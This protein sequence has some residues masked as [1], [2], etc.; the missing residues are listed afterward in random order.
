MCI[1]CSSDCYAGYQLRN[2][3]SVFRSIKVL[4][5]IKIMYL[6]WRHKYFVTLRYHL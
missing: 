6:Y 1:V 2:N 3:Y 5:D 4:V